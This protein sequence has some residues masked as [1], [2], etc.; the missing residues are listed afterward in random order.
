MGWVHHSHVRQD[1]SIGGSH[2]AS[3]GRAVS[4]GNQAK[5]VS[6]SKRARPKTQSRGV[7]GPSASGAR[8]EEGGGGAESDGVPEAL[9]CDSSAS[10][11]RN[12]SA[13]PHADLVTQGGYRRNCVSCLSLDLFVVSTR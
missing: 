7:E 4:E 9:D 10:G 2:D 5:R 1:V 6:G 8:G 13:P 3:F 11:R 12:R